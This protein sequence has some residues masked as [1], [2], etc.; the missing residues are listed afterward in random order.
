[1]Y[2]KRGTLALPIWRGLKQYVCPNWVYEALKGMSICDSANTTAY[3]VKAEE[4]LQ[5]QS[6]LSSANGSFGEKRR[7]ELSNEAVFWSLFGGKQRKL[8]L[9]NYLIKISRR[10][11]QP[12]WPAFLLLLESWAM[13]PCLVF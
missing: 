1:M 6:A 8:F 3:T 5:N 10:L 11:S 2:T 13:M 12:L 9:K 7:L 4:I